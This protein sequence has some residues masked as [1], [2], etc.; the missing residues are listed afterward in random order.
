[1][2]LARLRDVAL[3]VHWPSGFI[4][5]RIVKDQRTHTPP[6]PGHKTCLT[7]TRPSS[8]SGRGERS[9]LGPAARPVTMCATRTRALEARHQ[10]SEA[11]CASERW[12]AA[13][14]APRS[15]ATA[16]GARAA[17]VHGS[18]HGHRPPGPK[19]PPHARRR[20]V[21]DPEVRPSTRRALL[22]TNG[23]RNR[24]ELRGIALEARELVRSLR[25]SRASTERE[26]GARRGTVL[27]YKCAPRPS[28]RPL[29][30]LAQDART[31]A[32]RALLGASG[33][34]GATT[35][36]RRSLPAISEPRP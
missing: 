11:G 1:M 4:V 33:F 28:T 21:R 10:A 15:R 26:R 23:L 22:L 24:P 19:R 9:D 8:V 16:S 30:G 5:E 32:Q 31:G 7:V 29:R 2:A 35:S 17:A 20:D 18:R 13:A 6:R 12:S 34:A 3:C 27:A 25:S 14:R 36:P